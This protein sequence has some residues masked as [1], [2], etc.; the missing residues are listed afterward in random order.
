MSRSDAQD[1]LS[2]AR[3]TLLEQLLPAL[4]AG[5]HYEARMIASA[6]AMAAREMALE[7]ERREVEAASLARAL[8]REDSAMPVETREHLC[9]RI[10]Q[11][12]FDRPGVAR[13][14]LLGALR[15]MNRADLR[16]S[17]PKVLGH[18]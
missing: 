3:Q 9:R 14:E 17:N 5:L 13:D 7:P 10:R 15:E 2:T 18:V 8:G 6:M 16:I 11:G 1:L 4:P 12:D